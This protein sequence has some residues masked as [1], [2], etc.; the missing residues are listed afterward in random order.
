MK[1]KDSH[2][3]YLLI[4]ALVC[5]A[6]IIGYNALDSVPVYDKIELTEPAEAVFYSSAEPLSS[7]A[8]ENIESLENELFIESEIEDS[9]DGFIAEEP[10]YE[11]NYPETETQNGGNNAAP[12]VTQKTTAAKTTAA[13]TTTVKKAQKININTATAA[14]LESLPG[15]GPAKAQAIIDYRKKYGRFG[16]V[17]E[18]INVSGI[19]EKTLDKIRDLCCV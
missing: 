6:V 8:Q 11:E 16:S 15:I 19:G 7:S 14:E 3:L 1:Q 5:C 10:Q 12:A 2:E 13:K 17:E 4:A 9:N 18:L